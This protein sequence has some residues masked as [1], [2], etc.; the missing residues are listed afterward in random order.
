MAAHDGGAPELGEPRVLDVARPDV[1]VHDVVPHAEGHEDVR[2]H[3]LRVAGV[4]RDLGVGPRRLQPEGCVH[5]IVEGVD[6][7]VGR[8]RVVGIGVED[9]LSDGGRARVGREVALAVGAPQDRQRVEGARL[10][11]RGM[12]G[13][14]PGHRAHVRRVP[15]RLGSLAVQDVER[16]EVRRLP[17]GGRPRPPCRRRGRVAGQRGQRRLLVLLPPERVV[18]GHRLAPVRHGEVRVLLLSRPKGER[19]ILELEG[20]E[21]EDALDEVGLRRP[22]A[23][24]G[25][26][27]RAQAAVL[28]ARGRHRGEERRGEDRG[29]RDERRDSGEADHVVLLLVSGPVNRPSSA[30]ETQGGWRGLAVPAPDAE[31]APTLHLARSAP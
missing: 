28:C 9:G 20:M 2:R 23:G 29:E 16:R 22:A 26:V 5:G 21:E 4:R 27:D 24:V 15:L 1:R 10:H 14:Q 25:E 6:D 19:R 8:S 13:R 30:N 17:L 7:V 12:G 11:V 31:A 18:V 3:V